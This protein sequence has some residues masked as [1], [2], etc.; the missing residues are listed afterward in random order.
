MAGAFMATAAYSPAPC[1]PCIGAYRATVH[2]GGKAPATGTSGFLTINHRWA[3]GQ[4]CMVSVRVSAL[5]P[6]A[7]W[8]MMGEKPL[9]QALV[10]L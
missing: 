5:E 4:H 1:I 9:Q 7:H 2:D 8:C 3:T 10:V 6:I